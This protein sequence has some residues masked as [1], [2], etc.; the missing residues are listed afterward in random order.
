MRCHP[1]L[2]AA[3]YMTVGADTASKPV[4]DF[5]FST[6]PRSGILPRFG[7]DNRGKMPLLGIIA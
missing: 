5:G 7:D 3:Y 1:H 6:D 4:A 2:P